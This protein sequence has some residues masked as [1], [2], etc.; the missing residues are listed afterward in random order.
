MDAGASAAVAAGAAAFEG[1]SVKRM[2]QWLQERGVSFAD[3]VEKSELVARCVGANASSTA[4][5]NNIFIKNL[6]KDIDN[7]ALFDTFSDYGKILSCKVATNRDGESRGYGFIHFDTKEAAE[8]AIAKI[9]QKSIEGK[10]V[11]V[12]H[13]QA[14]KDRPARSTAEIFTNVYVKNIAKDVKEP[15]LQATAETF[16]A[17][18]SMRIMLNQDGTSKGFAFINYESHE[19]ASKVWR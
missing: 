3:C 1:W 8:N 12:C 19:N 13:F 4:G 15:A 6:A 10:V 11:T 17:I 7:K 14:K 9:D 16:G 5:D 18:T 2:K